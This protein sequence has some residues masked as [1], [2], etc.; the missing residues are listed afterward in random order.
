MEVEQESCL[1]S[2]L[3]LVLIL[4][5]HPGAGKHFQPRH[6]QGSPNIT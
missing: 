2:V 1:Q 6:G 5:A 4:Q 3:E